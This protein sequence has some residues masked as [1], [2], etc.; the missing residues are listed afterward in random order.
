MRRTRS[1]IARRCRVVILAFRIARA[2]SEP[3]PHLVLRPMIS[4]SSVVFC[5]CCSILQRLVRYRPVDHVNRCGHLLR[6]QSKPPDGVGDASDPSG[7]L[8]D[9]GAV[10]RSGPAA[11]SRSHHSRCRAVWFPSLGAVDLAQF[12]SLHQARPT[13][14]ASGMLD[15]PCPGRSFSRHFR[16]PTDSNRVVD[17]HARPSMVYQSNTAFPGDFGTRA[18]PGPYVLAFRGGGYPQDVGV[19]TAIPN[20][21]TRMVLLIDPLRSA[22]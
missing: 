22:P 19:Q 14:S 6:R 11:R 1:Q 15:R 2:V 16:R 13:R 21:R 8:H 18:A 9:A 4:A 7:H 3:V 12:G 17:G 10:H 5:R 20:A